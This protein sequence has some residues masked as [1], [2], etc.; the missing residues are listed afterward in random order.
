MNTGYI[1]GVFLIMTI[2]SLNIYTITIQ[3]KVSDRHPDAHSF[4]ELALRVLGRRGKLVVDIAIW[5]IQISAVI[6]YL[7]FIAWQL[8]PII[9][10]YTGFCDH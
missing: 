7:Y 4:S 5:M 8:N 1:G 9:C 6:S 3:L 2:G 10:G